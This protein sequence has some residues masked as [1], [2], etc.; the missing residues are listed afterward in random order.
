MLVSGMVSIYLDL[1]TGDCL[2]STIVNHHFSPP[3]GRICL[4]ELVPSIE[5]SQI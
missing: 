1:F 2:L 4:L 5:E 3:F